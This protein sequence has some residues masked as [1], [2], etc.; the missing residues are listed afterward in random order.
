MGLMA[1]RTTTAPPPILS[2]ASCPT[3]VNPPALPLPS[4]NASRSTPS[5][6]TVPG[7][8]RPQ[9]CN[10]HYFMETYSRIIQE[11]SS[12]QASSGSSSAELAAPAGSEEP[13]GPLNP[14]THPLLPMDAEVA[15]CLRSKRNVGRRLNGTDPDSWESPKYLWSWVVHYIRHVGRAVSA[16]EVLAAFKKAPPDLQRIGGRS[17]GRCTRSRMVVT[18]CRNG[19]SISQW[20]AFTCIPSTQTKSAPASLVIRRANQTHRQ[21]LGSAAPRGP[22][23]R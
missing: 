19:G 1:V 10:L 23:L 3:P 21:S 12:P 18:A 8:S 17:I 11:R 14:S 22:C 16:A 7:K 4:S 2:C 15:A 13:F 6:Y 20:R 5:S 9:F